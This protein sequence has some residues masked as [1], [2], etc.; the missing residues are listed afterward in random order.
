[1]TDNKKKTGALPA[2]LTIALSLSCFVAHSEDSPSQHPK[3]A[4][5]TILEKSSPKAH[6][7]AT[8]VVKQLRDINIDVDIVIVELEKLPTQFEEW[9]GEGSR[10]AKEFPGVVAGVGYRCEVSECQLFILDPRESALVTLSVKPQGETGEARRAYAIASVTREAI[11]GPLLSELTRLVRQ[12]REPA[13]PVPSSEHTWLMSTADE[14]AESLDAVGARRSWLWLEGGYRGDHAHPG[15]NPIHGPWIGVDFEPRKMLGIALA[16]GWLGL[17][18][19]KLDLATIQ[20]HRLFFELDLRLILP[21]GPAH[22]ALAPVFRLDV[23]FSE[24]TYR[25]AVFSDESTAEAEIQV[26]GLVTWH[27]PLTP[28]LDIVLGAGALASV[29]GN[30]QKAMNLYGIEETVVPAPIVRLA[31][32]AGI[33]WS[34]L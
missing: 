26:G 5:F 20:M 3:I 12:G 11:L 25:D 27:L 33:A 28:E 2:I 17:H 7:I 22:I 19:N 6:E 23:A 31:W 15:G 8:L 32:Q 13:P 14:G 30:E 9:I 18:E 10:L 1:M 24:T 21:V 34:P 16:S 29:L 4:F